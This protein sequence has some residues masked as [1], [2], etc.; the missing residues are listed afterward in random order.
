[1]FGDEIFGFGNGDEI[2]GE[3]PFNTDPGATKTRFFDALND[4]LKAINE[5]E[6]EKANESAQMI[7]DQDRGLRKIIKNYMKKGNNFQNKNIDYG[8]LKFIGP[9][10][11]D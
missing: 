1:M 4:A 8:N 3:T 10:M 5:K 6:K 11:S 7:F 2:V 9:D